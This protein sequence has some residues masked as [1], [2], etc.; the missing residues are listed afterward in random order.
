LRY[1]LIIPTLLLSPLF[2]QIGIDPG[3]R[4]I[5][6]WSADTVR[7]GEPVT[8]RLEVAL[9]PG[10]IPHFPELAVNDPAVSLVQTHLE[11]LAVEY[12]FSFWEL[13]RIVLPGV[14]VRI[15][16]P[17][18]AE[19]TMATDSLSMI[20][21]SVL[22]G[23]EQD[24]REI[25][26]MLAIRLTDPRSIW[27]RIGVAVL[28]V[29]LIAVIWHSRRRGKADQRRRDEK[30]QPGL[31]A[32]QALDR[33]REAPYSPEQSGDYY[34]ALSQILRRYL[35]QR[36]LFRALEMTTS[37]IVDLLP[38]E[39]DDPGLNALIGQV[40]EQADLA[41]F[42]GLPQSP[43]QWQRDLDSARSIIERSQPVFQ[44]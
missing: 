34:L 41:K 22:T 15:V 13:G 25:K 38:G 27:F 11:P 6:Q 44:V 14:P 21:A 33:L 28:L 18:G 26:G 20:V 40:L 35:E 43:E 32:L 1:F 8:L 7:V 30:L 4:L 19:V 10:S 3:V 36:L 37:E 23:Q 12:V 39:L 24:I 5:S 29:G 42:A 31:I 16:E 17:D 2:A 9:P